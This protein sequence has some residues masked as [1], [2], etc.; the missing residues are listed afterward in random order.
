[1]GIRDISV[2][3]GKLTQEQRDTIK[4]VRSIIE[5]LVVELDGNAYQGRYTLND[6]E[7]IHRFILDELRSKPYMISDTGDMVVISGKAAKKLVSHDI[8]DEMYQKTIAH[9]PQI[10]ESMKLLGD[11]PADK[12]EARFDKYKYYITNAKID[13]KRLT[14]FSTVG[15]GRQNTYYDQ[16]VFDGTPQD[17]FK[18]VKKT[19][20]GRYERLNKILENIEESD[21]RLDSVESEGSPTA[22]ST[23]KIT[24][25]N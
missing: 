14:I 18:D 10:I 25:S 12:Q 11:S 13:R 23:N 17:L 20:R 6:R 9:I 21:W 2:D 24:H 16:R 7:S 3:S 15:H 19:A 1:M 5:A 4:R 8:T 22:S